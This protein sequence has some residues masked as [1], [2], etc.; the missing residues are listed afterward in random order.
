MLEKA[1]ALAVEKHSGQVDKQKVPYILHPLS[2][3][4][5]VRNM[6]GL[7]E[8]YLIV[9]VLHDV[10]EDTDTT[11][12]DLI[13][14]NFNMNVIGGVYAVTKRDGENYINFVR[15]SARSEIGRVVKTA[16]VMDNHERIPHKLDSRWWAKLSAKYAVALAILNDNHAW[17]EANSELV[18]GMETT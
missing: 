8:D 12:E 2:V 14:M 5:R 3:M 16:D 9:A 10:V 17:L 18:A 15:R 1:I 13:A 4:T 6:V 7:K 11:L